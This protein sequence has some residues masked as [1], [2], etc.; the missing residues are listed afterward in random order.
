MNFDWEK[1]FGVL[2][3]IIVGFVLCAGLNKWTQR[4]IYT[5]EFP[6]RYSNIY[7]GDKNLYYRMPNTGSYVI[8]KCGEGFCINMQKD[9]AQE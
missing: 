3:W 9:R 1:I 8:A 4:N 5:S 2:F 6:P 7:V